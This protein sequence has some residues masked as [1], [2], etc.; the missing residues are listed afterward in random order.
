MKTFLIC[1]LGLA[2]VGSV[3][4]Q[5]ASN[6]SFDWQTIE[7]TRQLDLRN[8]N[9]RGDVFGYYVNPS[10]PKTG[11]IYNPNSG[12]QDIAITDGVE[13]ISKLTSSGSVYSYGQSATEQAIFRTKIGGT[14]TRIDLTNGGTISFNGP[15]GNVNIGDDD[16]MLFS[17]S[18]GRAYLWTAES[19][20][21]D[22]RP[23]RI[24]MREVIEAIP[25]V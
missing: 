8:I 14:E 4:A 5:I 25:E 19:G 24:A 21:K 2:L 10:G 22:T 3:N 13:V 16:R 11:F 18:I 17:D 15:I 9:D 12:F 6:F 1:A 7:S 20:T 23:P